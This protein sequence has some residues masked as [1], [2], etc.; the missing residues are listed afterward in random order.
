MIAL[1]VGLGMGNLYVQEL[2]K[3]GYSVDTVDTDKNKNPTYLSA[4]ELNV[5]YDIAVICTP[6]FTHEPIARKIANKC[7]IVLIEKPGVI[8]SSAWRKLTEDFP[9]TRFMMIKNNQY[10]KE[11]ALFKDQANQ[12]ERVYIRWN[13]SNR[14]PHPG[15]WFTTKELAF[16]GVSRDLMPHMLSYYCTLTDYNSGSKIQST[17]RQNYELK[18]IHSTDYGVVN[19]NGVFNVDDFCHFEFKNGNTTWILSSNWKTNLDHDD[20]SISF[21]MNNSAVK[22]DL[23]LCPEEAYRNMMQTAIENLNNDRFWQKQF[24]QDMWIHQQIE[25]L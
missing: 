11:I 9:N 8:N 12:S 17:A 20:S 5:H 3:L 1:V 4:D 24:E 2:S 14:I 25:N 6:N 7:S 13:N 22:Y 16:G 21:S 15:S 23:G 19:Q 18:D 10:R